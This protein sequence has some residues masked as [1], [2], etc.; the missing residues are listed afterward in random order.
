MDVADA[1]ADDGPSVAAV[2][3]A[4][5]VA[6]DLDSV[7]VSSVVVGAEFLAAVALVDGEA[8]MGSKVTLGIKGNDT[9]ATFP[10]VPFGSSKS[11][12]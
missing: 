12:V 9:D 3:V 5:A 6:A 8:I 1:S 11:P 4:V 7:F 10:E 2:A